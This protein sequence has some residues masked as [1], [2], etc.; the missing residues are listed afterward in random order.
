MLT[1]HETSRS[2]RKQL[3]GHI[4]AG[5]AVPVGV[6]GTRLDV[7][8]NSRTVATSNK[9]QSMYVRPRHKLPNVRGSKCTL[10]ASVSRDSGVVFRLPG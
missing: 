3:L 2:A 1:M 8:E 6:L 5:N 4:A 7:T 10:G 9:D